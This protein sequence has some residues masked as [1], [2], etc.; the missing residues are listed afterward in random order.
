[1][2]YKAAL[3]AIFAIFFASQFAFF[4][5]GIFQ[6]NRIAYRLIDDLEEY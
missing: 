5:G 6:I 1:M 3:P 2:D 4:G